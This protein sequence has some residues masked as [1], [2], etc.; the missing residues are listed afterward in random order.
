MAFFAGCHLSSVPSVCLGS[1][2]IIASS[3]KRYLKAELSRADLSVQ[4]PHLNVERLGD[5]ADEAISEP[6]S[7]RQL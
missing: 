4:I 7:V 3:P 6:N 5:G 1:N 2:E